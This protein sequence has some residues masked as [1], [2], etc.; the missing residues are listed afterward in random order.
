LFFY[1]I[2]G[3]LIVL[4][5]IQNYSTLT[6]SVSVRINLGFLSLESMALPFF[7]I[8]TALFFS[9]FLLATIVG[10]FERRS[11][12]KE[13]KR[14]KTLRPVSELPVKSEGAS[15]SSFSPKGINR[16]PSSEDKPS[17]RS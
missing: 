10:W 5:V 14:L 7:V 16:D 13:L 15:D 3:L 6:Y 12:S 8:A 1:G 11:L 2:L 9:G 17:S 4:F